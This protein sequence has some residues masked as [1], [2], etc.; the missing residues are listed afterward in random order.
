[1]EFQL[2]SGVFQPEF[3]RGTFFLSFSVLPEQKHYE[4]VEHEG[5]SLGEKYP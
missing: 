2:L 5:I 4:A 1:M 3:F